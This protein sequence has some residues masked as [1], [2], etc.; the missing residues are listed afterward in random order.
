MNS[1]HL[2]L[3]NT[4]LNSFEDLYDY[5]KLDTMLIRCSILTKLP[6]NKEK[7]GKKRFLQFFQNDLLYQNLVKC[8]IPIYSG[9]MWAW[10]GRV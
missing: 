2:Q 3:N 9:L 8:N 7:K 5:L 4:Y 6:V 1:T 10:F